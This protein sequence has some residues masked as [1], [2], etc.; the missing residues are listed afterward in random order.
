MSLDTKLLQKVVG[1]LIADRIGAEL[2]QLN[3]KPSIGAARIGNTVFKY[4]YATIDIIDISDTNDSVTNVGKDPQGFPIYETHTDVLFQISVRSDK[5]N[6]FTLARKVHKAF[7]FDYY[8]D[9]IH[10]TANATIG[11]ISPLT[12]I[13]DVLSDKQ[14][15]FNVFNVVLRV[16]D[17][18]TIEA[19]G[20]VNTINSIATIEDTKGV[21]TDTTL[22]TEILNMWQNG[23]YQYSSFWVFTD[24]WGEG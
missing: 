8:R 14:V 12:P 4:P 17:K 5:R 10:T 24:T 6:S 7:S 22:F 9:S 3:G 18:E 21:L 20:Y 15:E 23:V 1:D 19:E 11:R 16:N 2:S 13:P